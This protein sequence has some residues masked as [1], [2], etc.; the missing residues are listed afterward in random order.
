MTFFRSEFDR[1]GKNVDQYLIGPQY[2][3]CQAFVTDID[4]DFKLLFLESRL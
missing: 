3:T 4:V 1:I 2:I